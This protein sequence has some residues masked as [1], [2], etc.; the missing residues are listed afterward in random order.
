M[1]YVYFHYYDATTIFTCHIV[2]FTFHFYATC[3]FSS[4]ERYAVYIVCLLLR[5]HYLYLFDMLDVYCLLFIVCY[6]A[7]LRQLFD[8]ILLMPMR[9]R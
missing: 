6:L 5:R 1:T 2:T 9:R 4:Y 3:H 7:P 8:D